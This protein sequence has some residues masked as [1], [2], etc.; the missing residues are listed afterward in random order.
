MSNFKVV[1]ISAWQE[2]LNWQALKRAN[3]KGII[4]KIGEYYHLDDMFITHLTYSPCL[5][6]GD[7]WIQTIL[8][9]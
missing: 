1:D 8:A 5:K 4:I 6:A 3:I 7:S 2:N 9:Y